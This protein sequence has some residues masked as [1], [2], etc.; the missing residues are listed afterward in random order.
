MHARLRKKLTIFVIAAARIRT[1]DTHRT[2]P[3][4]LHDAK[5]RLGVLQ[6]VPSN[7]RTA[8]QLPNVVFANSR[9]S[10]G[11]FVLGT[12]EELA[13]R[14]TCI[15]RT[16]L[17]C[18]TRS[19]YTDAVSSWLEWDMGAQSQWI[20]EHVVMPKC[21]VSCQAADWWFD[22]SLQVRLQ[23]H[24]EPPA[25]VQAAIERAQQTT[26]PF[27]EDDTR[28]GTPLSVYSYQ[29]RWLRFTHMEQWRVGV[30]VITRTNRLQRD[31]S[32]TSNVPNLY[33]L[34]VH[35]D[36]PAQ[37]TVGT[38]ASVDQAI[39]LL[40]MV[41]RALGPTE[42]AAYDRIYHASAMWDARQDY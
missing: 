23:L 11:L 3:V 32:P 1:I 28:P 14:P 15:E 17:R 18:T 35:Y 12:F 40:G 27:A 29:V 13:Q 38:A 41:A 19:H 42:Q 22:V 26:N 5:L 31:G 7:E 37:S 21:V 8:E 30:S 2:H 4:R 33:E 34:M 39:Q 6:H 24:V 36:P 25:K 9:H 20:R 10:W 16:P